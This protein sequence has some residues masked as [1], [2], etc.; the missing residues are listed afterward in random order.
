VIL[1]LRE[2]DGEISEL[3]RSEL[4]RTG[5]TTLAALYT[6]R[7]QLT[8][9][10]EREISKDAPVRAAYSQAA[11]IETVGLY[12]DSDFLW[13]IEGKDAA[14]VWAVMDEL[15]TTL[16]Q[17]RGKVYDGVMRKIQNI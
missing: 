15:M 1:D 17:V 2:V 12:G 5:V 8:G 10:G 6:I 9:R 3:T 13:A 7:D 11:G 14:A 16:K 4:N